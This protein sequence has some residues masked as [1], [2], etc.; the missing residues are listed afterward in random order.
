MSVRP[1]VL[2]PVPEQTVRV[3]RAAFPKGCPVLRLRDTLGPVF[4]DADF[5]DLFPARGKPGL[6]PAMLTMLLLLQYGE[7]LSDRQAAQAVAA[8]IDWKYALGLELT[9]TGFDHSVLS[10][11]RDRLVAGDA[12]QRVLDLVLAAAAEKGLLKT[13]GRARTDSTH[14]L[15]AIRE[16]NRLELVGETLR[17]ALNEL[18]ETAP[19]WLAAHADPD[20]FD[21]YGRRVENYQLPKTDAQRQAWAARVGAD[22]TRLWGLLT[23]PD[24]PVELVELPQVQVLRRVWIQE[25]VVIDTLDE[26]RVVVMRD[27]KDRPPAAGRLVSPYEPDARTGRKRH[28]AWDGYKLHLTETC[29]P[30]RPR[31][32]THVETTDATVTDFEMTG[33]VQAGLAGRDLLP[34]EHLVDTGYV[35]A[36]EIVTSREQ[37][38]IE[39]VGPVMPDTARQAVAGQGYAAGDFSISWDAKQVSCPA[40]KR[41]NRW[42]SENNEHG[43]PIIKVRFSAT[44]CRPCPLRQS[45]TTASSH[46]RTLK[47]LPRAEHEAL[48]RARQQQK[49]PAW[50][51]KYRPR[52]GI[53]GTIGQ[54]VHR[55]GAR[56]ARYRGHP[57]TRLQH[58][59]TAAA[60]NLTRI[61]NWHTGTPLARTRTSR[62]AALNPA[63]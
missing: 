27:P 30:G 18:A 13:R 55:F 5:A 21:R 47:L 40:G 42:S 35:T 8:R 46:G 39:L 17:A 23:G 53:E 43:N 38:Q 34:G 31:L 63:A 61:D 24:A 60:L 22:G 37:H 3:A 50:Q 25:Y 44:D 54:A 56:Y 20:W 48:T 29:D 26:G 14:V 36:R 33:V 1:G 11:F 59:L 51:R 7:D 4:A 10:E 9:D 49:T 2:G 15:A 6:S 28:T 45:C 32:I 19:D 12:G 62:F 57:K 58:Q 52:A 41:S 16:V